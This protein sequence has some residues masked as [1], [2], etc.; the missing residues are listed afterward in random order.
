MVGGLKQA[1][2]RDNRRNEIILT[3]DVLWQIWKARNDVHF[4]SK[5]KDPI[6]AIGELGTSQKANEQN[7]GGEHVSFD[8]ASHNHNWKP[9]KKG[10][11]NANT[12]A[13][14]NTST[15]RRAGELQQGFI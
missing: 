10:C 11:D 6:V 12:D 7:S 3:M 2:T 4:N 15:N 13:A 1:L 5:R 9:P 8:Q 14:Q